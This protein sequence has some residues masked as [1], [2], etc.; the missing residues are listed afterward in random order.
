MNE[1]E[2]SLYEL[3]MKIK[4]ERNLTGA[5]PVYKLNTYF[6]PQEKVSDFKKTLQGEQPFEINDFFP[7]FL[8]LDNNNGLHELG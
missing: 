2:T 5:T 8:R 6:I 1:P 7:A 3:R 4:F